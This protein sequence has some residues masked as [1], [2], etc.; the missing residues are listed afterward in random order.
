MSAGGNVSPAAWIEDCLMREYDLLELL[1]QKETGEV[2]LWQHRTLGRRIIL[3]RCQGEGEV[4][5]RLLGMRQKNLPQVYEAAEGDRSLLVLEEYIEGPLLSDRLETVKGDAAKVRQ[6]GA[7]LCDAMGCLHSRGIIH[8]DIKPENVILQAGTGTLKLID[9]T[10][11]RVRHPAPPGSADTV[12]LGTAPYAAPEQFGVAQTDER[13]DIYAAGVLLNILMTG[14]HPSQ[15]LCRGKL[16]R[17][18][19]RC[20]RVNAAERFESAEKLKRA[21][22]RF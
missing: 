22:E 7:A 21:L 20:I 15:A 12:C 17:I 16:G 3:R 19:R 4:Y 10:A 1:S 6:L 2:S 8:R 5:R 11:A 14:Q 9:L 13:T 18:V